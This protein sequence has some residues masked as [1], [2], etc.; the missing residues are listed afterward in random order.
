[1][2][3]RLG[4]A[5]HIYRGKHNEAFP[6]SFERLNEAAK[7]VLGAESY[8]QFELFPLSG[9]LSELTDPSKTIVIRGGLFQMSSGKWTMAYGMADGSVQRLASNTP[10]FGAEEKRLSFVYPSSGK[11][12]Q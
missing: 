11:T 5:L 3:K 6:D 4:L 7:D 1:L 2:A 9:K 12:Q 8:E 10:D